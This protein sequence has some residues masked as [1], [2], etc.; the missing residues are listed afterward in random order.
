MNYED[1]NE[2]GLRGPLP[3]AE[4]RPRVIFVGDSFTFG[5]GVPPDDTFVQVSSRLMAESHGASNF[6]MNAGVPGYGTFEEALWLPKLLEWFTPEAVVVVFVPNDAIHVSDAFGRDH[7]LLKTG[8]R[9]GFTPRIYELARLALTTEARTRETED[10]YLSYYFGE[11]APSWANAR[12]DLAAMR[13]LCASQGTAFGL[14]YFPLLHDLNET[15]LL[16]VRDEV[17][18]ACGETGIPFLD[19]TPVFAGRALED[20]W[21]HPVD[22]HPNAAAHRLAAEALAPFTATLLLQSRDR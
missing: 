8:G 11:H 22:H 5:E 3:R 20:L 16:R 21:L 4:D 15:P 13:D 9:G 18:R 14:A 7:D 10:W 2:I 1:V 6:P 17:A 12:A 19:L